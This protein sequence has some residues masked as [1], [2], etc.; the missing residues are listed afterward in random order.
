MLQI[1]KKYFPSPDGGVNADDAAFIVGLNQMVNSENVRMG[2][3]DAGVTGVVESIGS[4]RLISA[5][6]P[7]VVFTEIGSVSDEENNRILYFKKN[8]SGTEDK[9]ICFDGNTETEYNVLLSSQVTGGLN[10]DKNSLIHSAAIIDNKLYWVEGENNEPRKINIESGIKA[11]Y[12]LFVTNAEPYV[13]PLDFSEITLIK[14]TSSYSPNISKVYD[15]VFS[16]NF[17]KD[18]S[19]EFA[20]EFIYYDNETSV[21]GAYSSATRLNNPT[22]TFNSVT[23]TMDFF[24]VIPS[25]VR[26][27]NLVVR[28]GNTNFAQRVKIWDREV[29][30]DLT[31][32]T[33]H[34]SGLV[35]LTYAFYNDTNGETLATDDVIRPYDNVPIY[36][37]TLETAKNRVYLANNTEGYNTPT[38]TSLEISL[39]APITLSGT[40]QSVQL[41]QV[42]HKYSNPN[43]P[44]SQYAYSAWYVNIPWISP[45]GY[46]ALTSTE[47]TALGTNSTPPLP[48]PPTTV[49]ITGLAFKG[50]TQSEVVANTKPVGYP[51]AN[52]VF[53][54]QTT[55]PLSITGLTQEYY[56]LFAQKSPYKAGVVFYDYAMRKCGVV[57]NDGIVVGTPTRNYAYSTAVAGIEWTLDNTNRLTEIPDWAYYYSIVRTLNQRTRFFIQ[58]FT[59]TAKYA[60]RD[61]NGVYQFTSNTFITG[62]VGIGLNTNALVQSGLGYQY[63]AGDICI[64]VKNDN[65]IYE[66]PV[67]GQDGNYI[68]VKA[69]DIG[70]LSGIGFIYE[71]YTPYKTS[72]QEPYFEIGEIYRINNPTTIDREYSA[73]SGVFRADSYALTRNFNAVTYFA[74]AMSPNDLFYQKWENDGGKVNFITKLG[75]V[76]KTQYISF[77]DVLIPNTSF[78]GLSTFRALNEKSV[79]QDCGSITKLKLTSKVQDQGTVMLA[80]CT[81]ES[82]S[83]YLGEVQITDSTGA[84]QFFQQSQEVLGTINTLKGSY[85]CVNPESVVEYRGSVWWV[86]AIN[87]RVAQ[88]GSNG[89][90]PI[91]NYKMTRFWKQFCSQYL[92]MTIAE[93][94]ALGSRPFIFG[95][96]DPRHNELLFSIPKLL[97]TPPKGYLPDYPS[98]IYP[99]DIYDGQE[100]TLVYNL[101]ANPNYWGGSYSF[102]PEGFAVLQNNLYSFKSGLLFKHNETDSQNNFYGTQYKSKVMCVSNTI[103]QR[104]KVYDNISVESNICPNF[105]YLYADYPYQQSSDLVDTDFKDLEGVYYAAIYR[106]KLTPTAIGFTTDSLLTGEKMRNVAMYFMVEFPATTQPLALKFLNIGFG[107]SRGHQT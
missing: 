23:V 15:S 74:G 32:I 29:S 8:T 41:I 35:P 71:I 60:T 30:A 46:Y 51:S 19:F 84:V 28:T 49:A 36:S 77:S 47:Q 21:V 54:T 104:P 91:S 6:Q 3:T 25:T 90:F 76:K 87:G 83:I 18:D 99:F 69:K 101:Q 89:L 13:F 67:V 93:I 39:Q 14:P 62:S 4:T 40:S 20:H 72:S 55:N 50:S 5:V 65:T 100:K 52:F 42:V 64:L 66:L 61:A 56:N 38:G 1:E 68:I 17:I 80:I 2:S 70:T 59:N 11:N 105:V 75:Q 97:A 63:T 53:F 24:Q 107:L 31:A 78:N 12:P 85:G 10:F 98:T 16:N 27:I 9:I 94:E 34:N 37:E 106:N 58:S 103:P 45:S 7:S 82:N 81:N 88:Y 79:P 57:T 96:V 48:T 92:S 22:D 33:N 95:V 86:D 44:A 26:I 73:L 43:A 102:S